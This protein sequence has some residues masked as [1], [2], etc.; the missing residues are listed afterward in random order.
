M[1]GTRPKL[2]L[3]CWLALGAVAC[4]ESGGEGIEVPVVQVPE[5]ELTVIPS[6]LVLN[7]IRDLRWS[8]GYLWALS[9]FEPFV[10]VFDGAGD[11]V[12]AFGTRGDGPGEIG[13]P[14]SLARPN[15][16]DP[17]DMYVWDAGDR[18]LE[19]FARSGEFVADQRVDVD[20]GVVLLHFDQT[21]Y[22]EPFRVRRAASG[23][24]LDT[25][26]GQIGRGSSLWASDLKFIVPG[27]EPITVADFGDFLPEGQGDVSW[28]LGPV[29]LW[30]TCGLDQVAVFDPFGE[31][32]HLM[33]PD[34]EQRGTVPAV[35]P[36]TPLGEGDVRQWIDAALRNEARETGIDIT[37]QDIRQLAEETVAELMALLPPASSPVAMRCDPDGRIWLQGLS[38]ETDPRGFG[39]TWYT[40]E[41]A[42]A[43]E[44]P[45]G[46][47]PIDF[48]RD[49]VFGIVTDDLDVQR[50]GWVRRADW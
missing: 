11:E 31:E 36:K 45:V 47:R 9:R 15:V 23:L 33:S 24:L 26:T 17:A 14:W 43:V 32:I 44:F 21:W 40:V 46:F 28:A 3:C 49:R 2:P 42:L 16:N 22:G 6:D 13:T 29:P 7:D 34:G 18:R 35:V 4:S 30:T 10:A 5:S 37:D 12:A 1:I 20:Y 25:S 48:Q 19:G 50:I 38:T 41:P 27:E 8:D 39:R